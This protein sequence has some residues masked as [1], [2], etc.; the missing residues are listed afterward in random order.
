MGITQYQY[1]LLQV[2]TFGKFPKMPYHLLKHWQILWPL[3]KFCLFPSLGMATHI[4]W[5]HFGKFPLFPPY[6]WLIG[7][8][9]NGI[10][11]NFI[12]FIIKSHVDH[13]SYKYGVS[14]MV[15]YKIPIISPLVWHVGCKCQGNYQNF[16]N[17]P[18]IICRL[19]HI[20][21]PSL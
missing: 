15:K 7:S 20:V 9:S 5:L 1:W 11:R 16:D 4:I 6:F 21:K 2:S 12:T 10:F 18:S 17:V 13:A 8:K 19:V 3:L 14:C